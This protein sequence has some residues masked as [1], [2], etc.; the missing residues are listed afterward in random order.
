MTESQ[1]MLLANARLNVTDLF[2]HKVNKSIRFHNLEHTQGVVL[3]CEEM[4]NYYQFNDEI[5]SPYI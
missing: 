4:A 3:A 5:A 2:Q 1:S